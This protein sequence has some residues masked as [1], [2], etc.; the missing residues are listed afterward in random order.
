MAAIGV[1]AT[2]D[3]FQN[4]NELLGKHV[5]CLADDRFSGFIWARGL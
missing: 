3:R 1:A 2:P 4:Q 5:R